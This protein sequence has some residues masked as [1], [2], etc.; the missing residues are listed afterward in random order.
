MTNNPEP[1][2]PK[3]NK[4]IKKLV[5]PKPIIVPPPTIFPIHIP[6]TNWVN[7]PRRIIETVIGGIALAAALYLLRIILNRENNKHP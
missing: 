4:A 5:E 2:F 1:R 3:I 6:E 7:L